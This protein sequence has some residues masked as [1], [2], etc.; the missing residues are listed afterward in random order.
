MMRLHIFVEYVGFKILTWGLLK[1]LKCQ[2][3]INFLVYEV[4]FAG[5]GN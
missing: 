2:S 3:K 5:N 1:L 4:N